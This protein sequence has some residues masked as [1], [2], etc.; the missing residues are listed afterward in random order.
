MHRGRIL[1][2]R[3]GWRGR[4]ALWSFCLGHV[5]AGRWIF[6]QEQQD[7]TCTSTAREECLFLAVE[8][9]VFLLKLF[10]L[11]SWL[12]VLWIR[13]VCFFAQFPG[14]GDHLALDLH[15]AIKFRLLGGIQI[16]LPI[17]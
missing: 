6:A 10:E 5:L 9:V 11:P 17:D 15:Q 3:R 13:G 4:I 2:R 14:H 8:L 1:R 7:E 12:L 16:P